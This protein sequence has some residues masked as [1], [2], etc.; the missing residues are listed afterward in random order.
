[1]AIFGREAAIWYGR[2]QTG[3]WCDARRNGKFLGNVAMWQPCGG[4]AGNRSGLSRRTGDLKK[5]GNFYLPARSESGRYSGGPDKSGQR[6]II[7]SIAA[8]GAIC[9]PRVGRYSLVKCRSCA[10][11][12]FGAGHRCSGCALVHRQSVMGIFS[13]FSA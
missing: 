10:L 11:L 3:V 9:L 5:Y 1:M 13:F 8:G 12:V 6:G 4:C 2:V 7:R